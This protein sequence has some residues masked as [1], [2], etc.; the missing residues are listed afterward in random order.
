[1]S[2]DIYEFEEEEFN[3]EF[4]GQTVLRVLAQTKPH[5][6]MVIG[7]LFFITAVAF[8][9]S[10]TTYLSA[11]IIDQGIIPGDIE[12][13]TRII[14]YYILLYL[15]QALFVF[16]F[17]YLAGM[18]GETVQYDLRK[19]LFD[20]LQEL[21]FSYFDRTPIGWIMSRVTSDTQRI[22]D[23]VSW[24]LLDV[25][26]GVTRI[27]S[28]FIFMFIISWQ[29][30]LIVALVIPILIVVAI[31]FK[32]KILVEYRIVRKTNS[33]ITGAYNENITGV[34]VT[35]A[36]VR[37]EQ[38]LSEFSEL[39]GEMYE[40]GYRAGW[41]SALFLPVVQLISALAIGAIALFGGWQVEIGNMTI[42]GIQAFIMYV[43]FMLWPI[44]ELARVYA[45][46]Q[47]AIASAER[48]FSLTDS[49][50]EIQDR[51]DAVEVPSISGDIVFDHVNFYYE[52][53]KPVLQDFNLHVRPGETIA[54]VGPTG[55][56]KST[57]VNLLA[58]FYEPKDGQ[59]I[60][61]G[62]DYRELTLHAIQSK[63]GVVL[64]TPH[65]F[66]GTIRENIRYGR[67]DASDEDIAAAAQLA[68]AHDFISTLEN[69][70]DEEVGEGGN[71]LSVGQKQLISLA[72]AVLAQPEIFIMDEA[73]S[74]VD[75]LT[76]ALIQQGM[77]RLMQ[78][79]TS[80]IIAHRLSTIKRADRIL[81]IEDGQITESGSHPELIRARGHYYDLYTRQF[82]HEREAALG[83]N[84]HQPLGPA[85]ATD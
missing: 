57:I 32:K 19:K 6:P 22:G 61:A 43:T 69:G 16:G 77:E 60:M 33:K 73:T 25:T 36:L 5:W 35:K 34:R 59:I 55:A 71:L 21:S 64:Q 37:E 4:N 24:G 76:E 42:G 12:A 20:R 30:A 1:M 49:V 8:M 56:G 17:I 83:G 7:F 53:D 10:A 66:S 85:F 28:A 9:D 78:D 47:Q 45:E 50:P 52:D 72:R 63:I 29:L 70:Y 39:T 75:T 44:Q 67:L 48:V 82:R 54:L 23:L 40:A 11:Q 74:S 3:T 65:L 46:M 41:L 51:P 26:W 79:C 31:Q 80:F 27:I 14:T 18:L 38:N 13:L 2:D 15:V 62:R 68:G 58:R 84:G 81:V